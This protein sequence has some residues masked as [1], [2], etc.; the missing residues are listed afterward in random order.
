MTKGK[1]HRRLHKVYDTKTENAMRKEARKPLY[2]TS[3]LYNYD[4]NSKSHNC[5]SHG[6]R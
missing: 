4:Y 3:P 5:S 1:L 2:R 6:Q